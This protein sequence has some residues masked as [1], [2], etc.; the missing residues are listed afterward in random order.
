MESRSHRELDNVPTMSTKSKI[1]LRIKNATSVCPAKKSNNDLED[2]DKSI[3]ASTESSR[4][5]NHSEK[6]EKE[7]KQFVQEDDE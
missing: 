4:R 5:K 3:K 1:G 7:A 6:K 2:D